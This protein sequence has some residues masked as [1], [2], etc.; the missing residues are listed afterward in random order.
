MA[1]TDFPSAWGLNQDLAL[2]VG[3]VTTRVSFLR[4]AL[5]FGIRKLQQQLL[6]FRAICTES[7]VEGQ[8]HPRYV[9]LHM[10]LEIVKPIGNTNSGR[11]CFVKLPCTSAFPGRECSIHRASGVRSEFALA[12][13]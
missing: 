3:D 4:R 8:G 5:L 10:S 12:K 6:S 11:L 13:L 9:A 1:E 7:A 2:H